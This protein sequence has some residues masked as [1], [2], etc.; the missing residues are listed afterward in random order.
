MPDLL[1][2]RELALFDRIPEIDLAELSLEL[3]IPVSEGTGLGELLGAAVLRLADLAR[4]GGLPWS[5]YDRDDLQALDPGELAAL[6]RLCGTAADVDSLIRS[7]RK[8]YR[9]YTNRRAPSQVAL[10][11]PMLLPPLARFARTTTG[12]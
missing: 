7:G 10:L 1:T 5:D 2:K 11:L 9:R 8:V 12:A 3:D 6:A 4:E